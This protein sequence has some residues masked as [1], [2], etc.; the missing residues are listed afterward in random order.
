MITFSYVRN[1]NAEKPQYEGFCLSTDVKPTEGIGNGSFMTEIDT[2]K[3]YCFD[4][5]NATWY[6]WLTLMS[7]EAA[8]QLSSLSV[9]PGLQ[10]LDL[11]D[12]LT[13]GIIKPGTF[14]DT[15]EPAIETPEELET[16]EP[17]E[18][19]DLAAEPD[20]DTIEE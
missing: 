17:A 1:I 19:E 4:E 15:L 2:G 11:G 14:Q 20:P 12:Q 6:E 18:I 8:A 9:A 7:A 5:E 16:E 3:V 10:Q 13:P